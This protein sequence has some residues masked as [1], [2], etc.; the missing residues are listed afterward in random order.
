MVQNTRLSILIVD[1]D[2]SVRLYIQ[3]VLGKTYD[4]HV[5]QDRFEAINK[6]RQCPIDIVLLDLNLSTE[7]DGLQLL[8]TVR[9]TNEEIDIIIISGVQI[10]QTVV[11]AM[12][13]GA[14][15]YICKPLQ[16][17]ALIIALERVAKQRQLQTSN[18][19]LKQQLI[20]SAGG[21][22]IIGESFAIVQVKDMI[23]KL[24]GQNVNVFIVG[25]TGTGKEMF[26]RLIHKQEQNAQRP[27][28]SVNC[29]AI[30]ENLL[31]S[32]LFGHERGAF[33]GATEKRLG[34]FELANGGDIFLDEINCLGPDLQAKLLRV[35]EEK[36]V[37]R[38]GSSVPKKIN[39]RVIAASNENIIQLV[40]N[41]SFRK[42]LFYRLNTV[43]VQ[44]PGLNE[45]REDIVPL[46]KHFLKKYRRSQTPKAMS[47][48]VEKL[49]TAHNWRGNVR[50]LKNTIEN[51][52]IF[53]HGDIIEPID[54]PFLNAGA[55][56]EQQFAAAQTPSASPQQSQAPLSGNFKE[57]V[58]NIERQLIMRSLEKNR[59][60]KTK[61]CRE[62]GIKRNKLYRKMMELGIEI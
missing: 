44:L 40:A 58:R 13:Q 37:E 60:N 2:Q 39:F 56:M 57:I 35:I 14:I 51:M 48:E 11:T 4:I 41:G 47:P 1:D 62:I 43:T 50:E 3:T 36:E 25:D 26:A 27:F 23:G 31:E 46:A 10:V 29:A 16:K 59:W 52:L 18:T 21:D 8:N 20:E 24:R 61:A 33:T 49:L 15:D 6:I 55:L 42:D 38:V 9:Q 53:S 19:L 54:I 32:M 34:K 5:A 12:Q 22:E 28:V 17:E 7:G 30:P 45:R